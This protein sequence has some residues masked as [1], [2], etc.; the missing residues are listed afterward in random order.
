MILKRYN[1]GTFE[2]IIINTSKQIVED[3]GSIEC[4][5]N[6]YSNI[7][8]SIDSKISKDGD[9]LKGTLQFEEK[10]SLVGVKK[11]DTDIFSDSRIEFKKDTGDNNPGFFRVKNILKDTEDDTNSQ[12]NGSFNLICDSEPT[13]NSKNLVT[14]GDIYRYID[15]I[16]QANNLNYPN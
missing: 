16:I 14:S 9:L 8:D 3:D 12:D 2:P 7:E 1:N 15:S 4:S 5:T 11:V 6:Q 10:S 13:Q